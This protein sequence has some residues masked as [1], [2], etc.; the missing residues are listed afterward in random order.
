ML[1]AP[2]CAGLLTLIVVA[3]MCSCSE[4]DATAGAGGF[5]P[6]RAQI[7]IVP[8]RLPEHPHLMVSTL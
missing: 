1:Q 8:K 6:H 5:A 2:A 4:T 7:Y 3:C